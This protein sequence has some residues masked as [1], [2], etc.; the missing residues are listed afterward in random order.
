MLAKPMT[1]AR[2][3]E[4]KERTRAKQ[5]ARTRASHEKEKAFGR[6]VRKDALCGRKV[7]GR[8]ERAQAQKEE[9][10][11]HAM[12]VERWGIWPRTAGKG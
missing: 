10:L 11:A 12:C 1:R 9:S 7:Q 4:R 5:R 8:K 2:K 6:A 3:V